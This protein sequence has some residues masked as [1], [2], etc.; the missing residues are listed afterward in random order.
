MASKRIKK[1]KVEVE[2]EVVV[3]DTLISLK[4][5]Y[6]KLYK[7]ENIGRTPELTKIIDKLEE[8]IKQKSK[9][10]K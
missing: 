4:D 7:R 10:T 5:R 8:A 6:F 2:P 1:V 9:E 3:D